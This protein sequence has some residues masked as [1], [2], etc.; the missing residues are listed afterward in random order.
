MLSLGKASGPESSN[1]S[2]SLP[3]S[4]QAAQLKNRGRSSMIETQ[5][6]RSTSKEN[7][8][9]ETRSSSITKGYASASSSPR[10]SIAR[11]RRSSS[12]TRSLAAEFSEVWSASCILLLRCSELTYCK[13]CRRQHCDRIRNRSW[14][15]T[16]RGLLTLKRRCNLF[17]KL[18]EDEKSHSQRNGIK[19]VRLLRCITNSKG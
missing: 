9:G 5:M 16:T 4:L 19:N 18:A 17:S 2:K 15:I 14:R 1:Y 6:A 12:V 10:K 11:E 7:N 13:M 8:N 3:N